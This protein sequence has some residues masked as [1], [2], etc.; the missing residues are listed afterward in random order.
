M[1]KSKLL[2]NDIPWINFWLTLVL[3]SFSITLYM[4][5][6]LLHVY[7]VDFGGLDPN[8]VYGT[9]RLLLG[10]PLYQN[11]E[12]SP[13]AIIQYMPIYYH[14]CAWLAAKLGIHAL[15]VQALYVLMRTVALICNL[16]TTGILYAL[17]RRME[18]G[19]KTALVFSLPIFCLFTWHYFLRCDSLQILGFAAGMYA[20]VRYAQKP[21]LTWI[22]V[23]AM[24]TTLGILAKQNGI[25]LLGIAGAWWWSQKRLK[26]ALLYTCLS[27]ISLGLSLALI[28]D[29]DWVSF[30]QNAILGLEN[31]IRFDFFNKPYYFMIPAWLFAVIF[32]A[33]YFKHTTK[34]PLGI[35]LCYGIAGCFLFAA[36][37][38]I[39]DGSDINYFVEMLYCVLAAIPYAYRHAIADKILFRFKIL[40]FSLMSLAMLSVGIILFYKPYNLFERYEGLW[41]KQGE[42][43]QHEAY[44]RAI[45]L[46]RYFMNELELKPEEKIFIYFHTPFERYF[47][48]NAF[49]QNNVF[50]TKDL[51]YYTYR[52]DSSLFDYSHFVEHMNAG[53]VTYIISDTGFFSGN[54]VIPFIR[55]KKE[56]FTELHPV[57]GYRIFKYSELLSL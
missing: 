57:E 40:S 45:N 5:I 33:R 49:I 4:R 24:A 13:Y 32:L 12:Q 16:L 19:N 3:L 17:I 11:P 30:Y 20:L 42:M 52:A 18:I 39:K 51:T 28:I 8:V 48:D 50:P 6:D 41:A 26:T 53:V 15:E 44:H 56:Q 10:E 7:Y 55:F 23:A 38:V 37:T 27:I 36:V 31:G 34:D 22:V 47:L 9:Q 2:K 14:L 54:E 1:M 25:M 35:L 43:H 46:H 29:N 21:A